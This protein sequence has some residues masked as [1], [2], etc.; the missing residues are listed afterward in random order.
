MKALIL[1]VAMWAHGQGGHVIG[2]HAWPVRPHQ[3]IVRVQFTDPL[4]GPDNL[5]ITEVKS[6]LVWRLAPAWH[7]WNRCGCVMLTVR[8]TFTAPAGYRFAGTPTLSGNG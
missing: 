5:A 3:Q 1:A 4:T 8:D 6:V 7:A 2:H